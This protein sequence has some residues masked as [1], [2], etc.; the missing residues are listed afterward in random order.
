MEVL[1]S[2][3]L[4]SLAA[5]LLG[6]GWVRGVFSDASI[7]LL[8]YTSHAQ[9]IFGSSCLLCSWSFDIICTHHP[10]PLVKDSG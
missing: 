3:L 6:G 10:A 5:V 4:C 2:L 9:F 8:A 7:G 1:E